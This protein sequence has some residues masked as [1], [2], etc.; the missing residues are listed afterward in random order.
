[1]ENKLKGGNIPF[2]K[3]DNIIVVETKH[4]EKYADLQP[5]M[6]EYTDILNGILAGLNIVDDLPTQSEQQ[7]STGRKK[8]E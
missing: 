8:K 2:K 7:S 4:F 1:V 6:Q 5:L 3:I